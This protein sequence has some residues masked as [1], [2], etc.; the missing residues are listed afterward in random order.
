MSHAHFCP[1]CHTRLPFHAHDCHTPA[2]VIQNRTRQQWDSTQRTADAI[3][4]G[5]REIP[6]EDV[7]PGRDCRECIEMT[8]H[9]RFEDG[10]SNAD[11][12]GDR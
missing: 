3:E 10:E 9:S 11:D 7:L 2:A 1:E 6:D 8:G 12:T 4:K 5:T